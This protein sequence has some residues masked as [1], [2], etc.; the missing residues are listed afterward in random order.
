MSSQNIQGELWGKSPYGWAEVQEPQH[1]PLWEAMLDAT[2]VGKNTIFLDV[3]CGAGGSSKLALE[4]GAEVHGIDVAEGLISIAT[5]TIA[6]GN[7]K[8]ADIENLPYKD[9]M[10]DVVYAANSLQY[11]ENRI[12][13]LQELSRVC[14]PNGKIVAGLF[15]PPEKVD[16]RFIFKALKDIMPEA[17]KGGGPFELSGANKL[18]SLFNE[19]GLTNIESGEANCPFEYKDFDTMWYGNFSA[20]PIQGMLKVVSEKKIKS[21][22][23][24]ASKNFVL[25]DGRYLIP[26]N[27][28]KYV[29]A[30]NY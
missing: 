17:P 12:L 3:G 22:F 11:S 1:K 18:E 13:A 21:A 7:F 24:D 19:A 14:K 25:D 6:N 27:V 30:Y 2:A 8:I 15:G 20:G 9:N 28:F 26:Q 4:R 29:L 10:F 16:Y 5:Q 23:K